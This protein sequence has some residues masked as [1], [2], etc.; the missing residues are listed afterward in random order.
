VTLKASEQTNMPRPIT[1]LSFMICSSLM[2]GHTAAVQ[3]TPTEMAR[4][5]RFVAAHLGPDAGL[6]Q[7][8]SFT[9]AGK[10]SEDLQTRNLDSR[11]T[12]HTRTYTD[13]ATGMSVRLVATVYHDFPAV[14]WVLHF[15]NGG[16]ADSPF[17]SEVRAIDSALA[18]A[19][20]DRKITLH[21]ADGSHAIITDFQPRQRALETGGRIALSSFG[22]RSSDGTLPFFNLADE[23]GGGAFVDVG[24]TGQ[25]TAEFGRDSSGR[26]N[27][28]AGM[29]ILH[30]K[31]LPAEQIRTPSILIMFWEGADRIRAQNLH[32]RLLLA[33][34][35]PTV[36]GK[37]VDPP[38]A[39]SPHAVVGF[40]KTTEANML[41]QLGNIARHK[42]RFDYWW[43][44]AGW[45]SCGDNWARFVGNPDPDPVRFPGGL[46]PVAQ[47]AERAG[48]Q[49]LLWFEPERVM[50]DTTI[51]KA[52][53][54][55]LLPPPLKMPADLMYQFNDGFHLLNL[56]NPQALAW[57]T[58]YLSSMIERTGITCY[59]NDFNMY[60]AYYW[61]NNEAADRQGINEIRYV[62]G[63]YQLCDTLRER[64]PKLLIDN[65][66]SGGR[67]IDLE[68]LRR[69]IVLTRSDYLWDPIGQQCHT[70]GLAQWIP[71]TGIGAASLDIY[72]CRSGLGSH[73]ALAA[74]YTSQDPE[75][76]AAIARTVNEY[77]LLKPYFTGDFYPLGRYSVASDQ[78]MAWQFDRPDLGAGMVQAFRR[79]ACSQ[80]AA[81]YRLSGLES[82]AS[83]EL[84]NRDDSKTQSMTGAELMERGLPITLPRKPTAAI[85]TYKKMDRR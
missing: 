55:W 85:I 72:S 17:V 36:N 64:H 40:E 61:R 6:H 21:Y 83:Y 82:G 11:R 62:T 43:I 42:V 18:T 44:D 35:T 25:W 52:H 16:R 54:D 80:E 30:T 38:I 68:M 73:F 67:R 15:K 77:R 76:W 84:T 51:F 33:H 26:V 3:P 53:P 70:Y 58:D 9:L 48:M 57:V 81:T 75:V 49:F 32:R 2:A 27:V 14:E 19:A 1:V 24:W 59:R 37:P 10:K 46:K 69:A 79:Q 65:C 45:Y 50:R 56:G 8:F 31:L 74:G 47:A 5:E 63:F 28:R 4:A 60:P 39:A 66:A 13:P 78:W 29:E 34:F 20:A 7:P 71:I 23:D 41:A 22:G 12:E